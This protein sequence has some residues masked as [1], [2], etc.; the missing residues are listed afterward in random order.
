[1]IR[2]RTLEN[3]VFIALSPVHDLT[4]SP[5]S[6]TPLITSIEKNSLQVSHF[7]R[8]ISTTKCVDS[9]ALRV[10]QLCMNDDHVQIHLL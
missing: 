4:H 1:M 9:M 7:D 8:T 3:T 6:T 5:L 10:A 2:R